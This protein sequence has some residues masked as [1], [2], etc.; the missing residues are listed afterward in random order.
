MRRHAALFAAALVLAACKPGD[1]PPPDPTAAAA[2]PAQPTV[3]D[4]I[5]KVPMDKAN[6][7]EQDVIDSQNRTDEAMDKAL[8]EPE[9]GG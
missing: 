8:E 2:Q 9:G 5:A 1:D 6:A 7:L 4:D 3:I